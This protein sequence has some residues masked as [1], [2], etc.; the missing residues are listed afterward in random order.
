MAAKSSTL[1]FSG[2]PEP[3]ADMQA[4]GSERYTSVSRISPRLKTP[5]AAAEKIPASSMGTTQTASGFC[6]SGLRTAR[7]TAGTKYA[8]T[9]AIKSARV[10]V[11][12]SDGSTRICS[13][14]VDSCPFVANYLLLHHDP[15]LV[16]Q[17]A[18]LRNQVQQALS[19]A[20]L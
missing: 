16:Q 5:N 2:D 20:D 13:I 9:A 1:G 19:H 12:M 17:L 4:V 6:C 8:K 3:A 10:T 7:F 18:R 14:R 11:C 15:A